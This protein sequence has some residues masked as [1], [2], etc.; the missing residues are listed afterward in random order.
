MNANDP[1]DVT[2]DAFLISKI[3]GTR[4]PVMIA[5]DIGSASAGLVVEAIKRESIRIGFYDFIPLDIV[6]SLL[7]EYYSSISW[8][9]DIRVSMHGNLIL[10]AIQQPEDELLLLR[11]FYERTYSG[12]KTPIL[13]VSETVSVG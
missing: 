7:D 12:R 6:R 5:K 13:A 8:R 4:L 1:L 3:G 11:A 9:H 2:L 10:G